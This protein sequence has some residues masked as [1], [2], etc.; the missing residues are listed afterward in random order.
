M[1]DCVFFSPKGKVFR[2]G[3]RIYKTTGVI[4]LLKERGCS[5]LPSSSTGRCLVAFIVWRLVGSRLFRKRKR[6]LE[7]GNFKFERVVG[8]DKLWSGLHI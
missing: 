6:G 5:S 4:I 2:R 3:E 7:E 1:C 8:R